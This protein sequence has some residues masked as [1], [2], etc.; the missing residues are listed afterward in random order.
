MRTKKGSVT[1]RGNASS[2][3]AP[4]GADDIDGTDGATGTGRIGD[5]KGSRGDFIPPGGVGG[6]DAVDIAF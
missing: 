3:A 5:I 4:A 1:L 6:I 2:P